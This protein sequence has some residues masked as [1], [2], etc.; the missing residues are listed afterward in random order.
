MQWLCEGSEIW[1]WKNWVFGLGKN[2]ISFCVK[3][4]NLSEVSDEC[5]RPVFDHGI[6][7]GSSSSQWRGGGVNWPPLLQTVSAEGSTPTDIWGGKSEKG[8]IWLNSEVQSLNLNGFCHQH[9]SRNQ[10]SIMYQKSSVWILSG[11]LISSA[12]VSIIS[13]QL[14][15]LITT[16]FKIGL[17]VSG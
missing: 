8:Q 16:S 7:L 13:M 11:L 12:Q 2:A 15:N 5:R 17:E 9:F 4:Y 1:G 6:E 14:Q 3:N 10:L